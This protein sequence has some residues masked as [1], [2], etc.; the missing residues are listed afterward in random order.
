MD[1]TLQGY[2]NMLRE[3]VPNSSQ[4]VYRLLRCADIGIDVHA[5]LAE[6]VYRVAEQ[7]ELGNRIIYD[8]MIGALLRIMEE[9]SNKSIWE[10]LMAGYRPG[11][12]RNVLAIGSSGSGKTTSI[13]KTAVLNAANSVVVVDTK[14]NLYNELGP[15]M[16][17]RDYEVYNIDFV[18]TARSTIGAVSKRGSPILCMVVFLTER[19][20]SPPPRSA[21][22]PRRRT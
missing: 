22:R 17:Q 14:G 3:Q 11:M 16:A 9:Q 6:V 20:Q 13:V 2:I 8:V 1:I 4:E 12:N 7:N 18:S 21:C 5:M 19:P 15:L 10:T